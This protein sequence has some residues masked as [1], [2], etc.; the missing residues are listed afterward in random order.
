[1]IF[2]MIS[3]E[4]CRTC[5]MACSFSHKGEFNP[6]ISSIKII[7]KES[8]SGFLV[9][10]MEES[11]SRIMACDG[12]RKRNVPLCVQYCQNSQELALILEEFLEKVNIH[13]DSDMT[14]E[15]RGKGK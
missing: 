11:D 5:E 7:D 8:G 10:I 12:C 15:R 13:E 9:S 14:K 1:M 6:S 2:D 4:G 3:C